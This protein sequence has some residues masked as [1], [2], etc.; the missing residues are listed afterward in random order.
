MRTREPFSPLSRQGRPSAGARG[1]R[2]ARALSVTFVALALLVPPL[3]AEEAAPPEAGSAG[4][5]KARAR[6]FWEAKVKQ[7]YT[8]QVSFF[9]PKVKRALSV[10]DY[11]KRQG[12]VQYLE[13]HV[14]GVTVEEA[15]GSVTVLILIQLKL[16]QQSA[17]FKQ[18]T[19]IHEEWVRRDGEWYR[20]YPQ[21]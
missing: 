17:P 5:L 12:P 4:A 15:R 7:D 18:E 20:V 19:V 2:I 11:I 10:N 9:E 6:A 8:A 14:D 16:L 21:G 3:V 13:A 1:G